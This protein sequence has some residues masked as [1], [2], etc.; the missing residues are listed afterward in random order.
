M[1]FDQD[2]IEKVKSILNYYELN[3]EHVDLIQ[4]LDINPSADAPY[5]NAQHLMTVCIAS[6]RL[7]QYYTSDPKSHSLRLLV[8]A[9]LYHDLNHSLGDYGDSINVS[10]AV[11]DMVTLMKLT[12]PNLN[13]KDI[14]KI[15]KLILATEYPHG[16]EPKSIYH[17]IIQD[18]DLLQWVEPDQERWFSGLSEEQNM[19]VNLETTKHFLNSQ[20]L[21]T[22]QARV[23][24]FNAGLV[25][26]NW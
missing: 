6:T 4:D 19:V 10:R 23:E 3:P 14:T 13:G 9:S 5:H 24:L 15:G 2:R 12:E 22:K 7:G 18:S 25:T 21:N 20:H 17:K 8:L 16:S 11:A 1:S 26:R